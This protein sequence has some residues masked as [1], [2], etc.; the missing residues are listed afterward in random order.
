MK[1]ITK[2]IVIVGL[3]ALG[4]G[5]TLIVEE[6][7]SRL[8][9]KENSPIVLDTLEAINQTLQVMY[10]DKS[11]YIH[12]P[13]L[14]EYETKYY[15]IIYKDFAKTYS[16]PWACFAAMHRVESNYKVTLVSDSAA[17]GIG[18]IRDSTCKE[19][20]RKLGIVYL[21]ETPFNEIHALAVSCAYLACN[22]K[23]KGLDWCIRNYV[24]GA[25]WEEIRKVNV[26]TIAN[27]E[28][29]YR[30]VY[31]EYLRINYVFLGKLHEQYNKKLKQRESRKIH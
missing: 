22:Y 30:Y 8:I 24:S 11:D 9:K 17:K 28:K 10:T 21:S 14:S 23:G 25:G 18:Q 16:F 12:Y 20:C 29:Y 5:L 15:A 2:V 7:G 3:L 19:Q 31:Y 4:C 13:R 27:R 26:K 1:I 6:V